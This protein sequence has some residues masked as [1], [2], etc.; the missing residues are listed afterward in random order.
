MKFE[1]IIKHFCEER[2]P[3]GYSTLFESNRNYKVLIT[4]INNVIQLVSHNKGI[5]QIKGV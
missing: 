1:Q 3:L 5:T 2:I 4:H